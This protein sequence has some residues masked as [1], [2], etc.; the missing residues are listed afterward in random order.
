MYTEI[1]N[2]KLRGEEMTKIVGVDGLMGSF[3]LRIFYGVR[4]IIL[5]TL[6]LFSYLISTR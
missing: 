2:E 4:S 3:Y 5:R 6:Y 1:Q